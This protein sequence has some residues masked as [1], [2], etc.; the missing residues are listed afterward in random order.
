MFDLKNDSFKSV[1]D[2]YLFTLATNLIKSCINF[3]TVM[4]LARWLGPDDFGRLSYLLASFAAIK[5]FLDMSSSQAFFTF[6]SKSQKSLRFITYYWTWVFIQLVLTIAIIFFLLPDSL[7]QT[8]WV[9]EKKSLIFL[10][11]IAVFLQNTAWSDIIQ[12]AEANRRTIAIQYI[13]TCLFL[14]HFIVIV[15]LWIFGQLA[16]PAILIATII[17][18]SI[19]CLVASRLYKPYSRNYS[20]GEVKQDTFKQIFKSYGAFCLPLIPYGWVS[21]VHDLGDRWMLQTW[22][23]PEQQAYFSISLQISGMVLFFSTAIIRIFW[24]EVAEAYEKGDLVHVKKLYKT[25]SRITYFIS[26]LMAGA[27]IPWS[28]ELLQLIA[29]SQYSSG[30]FTLALLL[31]VPIYQGANHLNSS[32]LL[33]TGNSYI[34]MQIGIFFMV[35]GLLV[36]YL[37]LAPNTQYI[38][39]LDLGAFGLALKFVMVQFICVNCFSYTIAKIFNW[40]FDILFQVLVMIICVSCGFFAKLLL[41]FLVF[42]TTPLMLIFIFTTFAYFLM[43]LMVIEA[44]L[45]KFSQSKLGVLNLFQEIKLKI[46]KVL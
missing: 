34:Y 30:A 27:L 23:G 29:G 35:V 24:K 15:C 16:L 6:L 10:G 25:T 13:A 20:E 46:L 38:P 36:T 12:M 42:D 45:H 1:K 44:F 26:S 7:V 17:E 37:M 28:L 9:D 4:L 2:R 5:V 32:L 21:F 41:S 11:L 3:L 18:W 39:G 40:E 14:L 31:L 19:T 22:G 43:V 8:I 33:A